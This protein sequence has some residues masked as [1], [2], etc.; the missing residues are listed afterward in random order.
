MEDQNL[1]NEM[2]IEQIE[3]FEKDTNGIVIFNSL[4]ENALSFQ[5]TDQ[6]DI[7]L[8]ID[9]V[10]STNGSCPNVFLL[11]PAQIA[12]LHNLLADIINSNPKTYKQISK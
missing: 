7:M 11:E 8:F 12:Y 4:G 6:A 2:T 1:F 5:V 3:Q 10:D 9:R